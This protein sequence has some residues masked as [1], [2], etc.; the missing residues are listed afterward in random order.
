MNKL[1]VG[2][3][4]TLALKLVQT[5]FDNKSIAD[6]GEDHCYEVF[7]GWR[8]TVSATIDGAMYDFTLVKSEGGEE[9]GG[10]Y[11]ERVIEV[12]RNTEVLGFVMINGYYMSY[13]GT[14]FDSSDEFSIVKPEEVVVVV[15]TKL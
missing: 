15:Y 6:E 4:P 5:L 3:N 12:S 13:D 11:V 1:I 8:N 7:M 14:S 2:S 10:E 9:G